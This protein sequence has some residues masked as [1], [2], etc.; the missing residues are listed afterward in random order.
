MRTRPFDIGFRVVGHRTATRRAVQHSVA[1]VAYAGCDPRA[2]LD[3]EAY[4]SAFVFDRGFATYLERNGSEAGF[5]GPCG[6]PW[7]WW[8]VDRPGDL[9]AAQGDA[10]RLAGATLDRYREL[11][12]DDLLIFLSGGKGMHVGIPAV[13]HPEPSPAFPAIAKRFCLDRAEA[14]GVV[15]DPTIYSKTRLFR[16]PNSRHPKTGLYKRRLSLDELTYLTPEAIVERARCPEPF[17]IPTGPPRCLQAADDW[18]QARRAVEHR[19]ERHAAPRDGPTRLS[20]FARRFIRDGELE[21][22]QREVS[23][24]RVAAELAEVGLAGGLDGL[25]FA[26]REES[27]RDSGLTPSD[28]KHALEGGLAHARRQRE[29]GAA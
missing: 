12:D 1:F 15:A 8:D 6:A 2:E 26:L 18:S 25:V 7:L 10:R 16:A 23:T 14:A 5:N 13:W 11:D 28:V 19:A 20:A 27:A 24:F 29:G 22:G 9:R 17:D 3:R 4:L 21:P